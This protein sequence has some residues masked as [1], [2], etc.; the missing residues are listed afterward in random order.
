MAN[1][2][3]D[4]L[5]AG[6]DPDPWRIANDFSD[7]VRAAL[8]DIARAESD[9]SRANRLNAWLEVHQP[10][11]F[12]RIAAQRGLISYCIIK[13]ADIAEGDDF[14]R[15]KIQDARTAWTAAAMSG[16]RSGFVIAV[17]DDRLS[18]A[19]PNEKVARFAQRLCA[20]YL[21]IDD[22]QAEFDK[23]LLDEIRLEA[24]LPDRPT[25]QW[26]VGVNYFSAQGDRR[27]W[28][29]H[30][31]PAG[32]A[33]SMN[34]VGHMVKATLQSQ[35]LTELE[36]RLGVETGDHADSKLDSLGKALR[37]AMMTIDRAAN[38]VSGRATWLLPHP[39]PGIL[40]G[41]PV[42]LRPPL[43][44]KNYSEYAGYY[45]TDVTL[46][47]VY[48]RPDVQRPAEVSF[49]R[50]DFTYLNETAADPID[51]RRVGAGRRVRVGNELADQPPEYS[52]K[53]KAVPRIADGTSDR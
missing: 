1:R 49:Q 19:I 13:A 23:V 51:W 35:T 28:H 12:G 50:L 3:L 20:L 7:D 41:C 40:P 43:A 5:L 48:F 27:W 6:L 32:I 52:K 42:A 47:S 2:I 17:D 44:D 37:L 26:D 8:N 15:D 10:C 31:I 16:A 18:N 4:E 14:V 34:S 11:L 9:A 21:L 25:W 46:P 38:A 53:R 33:F 24:Q 29:D 39:G 30:R 22:D 45:H 36:R